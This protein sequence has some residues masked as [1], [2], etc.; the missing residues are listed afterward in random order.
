MPVSPERKRELN[1]AYYVENRDHILARQ[2]ELSALPGVRARQRLAGRKWRH[3]P[4]GRAYMA[5]YVV[6]AEAAARNGRRWR[7]KNPGY[8]CFRAA[9]KRG[10]RQ[11]ATPLWADLEV[12]AILY[13][14]SSALSRLTGVE[15]HVDHIVPLTSPL[16]CGLHT[17]ANL[18]VIPAKA[19]LTKNNRFWPDMPT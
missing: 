1:A 8:V 2:R 9:L 4:R 14:E 16:V 6:P 5:A 3:S 12:I 17:E 19:N 15:F 13:G 7:D 11:Q 10:R 18:R